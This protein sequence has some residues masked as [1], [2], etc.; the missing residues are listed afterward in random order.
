MGVALALAVGYF[1]A[2]PWTDVQLP[3]SDQFI[4]I[5]DTILFLTD[6]LTAALLLAQ[7]AMTRSPALLALVCG[8]SFTALMIVPHALTFPG[9]FSATGLLGAALQTTVWVYVFWHLGLPV[10]VLA[11]VLLRERERAAPQPSVAA[12]RTAVASLGATVLAA[13]GLAA[14]AIGV[15]MPVIMIDP[16]HGNGRWPYIAGFVVTLTGAAL[17]ALWRSRRSVLDLWLLVVLWAWLIEMLLL[18]TTASRFSLVWYSG[19]VYG[20]LSAS[21]V[22]VALLAQTTL[23]Y[24]RLA[25]SVTVRQR[26]SENRLM[27]LDAMAASIAHEIKQP[28]AAIVANGGAG[29]LRLQRPVPDLGE[30]REIL[31]T[32]VADAMRAGEVLA[33]IRAL[34]KGGDH[35]AADVDIADVLGHALVFL[36]GDLHA[37][38]VTVEAD[39]S[40]RLPTLRAN[41]AQLQQVFVNLILNAIEAM[42]TVSGRARTLG[43]RNDCVDGEIRVE[44]QDSGLGVAPDAASRIFEAFY[45]TKERGTGMGLAICKSIVESH[46]GRLWAT[47]NDP[48][49]AT[50]HIA[51][52]RERA[53][54]PASHE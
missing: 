29:L 38:G 16:Q 19:R 26:E 42:D 33:G 32:I 31:R 40:R 24:A 12:R 11:Y 13:G 49:G 54:A 23:L 21:F 18:S 20:L 5:V 48:H 25:S 28:L 6:L 39:L 1:A 50:F 15:A 47:A 36:H 35:D 45:T 52:P 51:L 14:L 8:Y 7:F 10:S 22:L 44:V 37:H 46:G 53:A 41:K 30:T 9:A 27:T 17:A 2:A 4:P 3:A 34:V 43:I